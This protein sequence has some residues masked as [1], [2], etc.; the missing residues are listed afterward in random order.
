MP[1]PAI[2]ELIGYGAALLTTAA[3]VPQAAK[4]WTTRDLSGISLS[5]YGLFTLG[6]GLWLLYGIAIGSWPVIFAN[7]ITLVLAGIV[8]GLKVLDALGK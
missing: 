6:V 1:S 4:S 3:F 7:G 8:L 2:H 5:M